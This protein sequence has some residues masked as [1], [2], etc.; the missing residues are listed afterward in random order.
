MPKLI[1]WPK[2]VSKKLSLKMI[3]WELFVITPAKP[4]RSLKQFH[5]MPSPSSNLII[6]IALPHLRLFLRTMSS[7]WKQ[8]IPFVKQYP[9]LRGEMHDLFD[10]LEKGKDAD[11]FKPLLKEVWVTWGAIEEA[12]KQ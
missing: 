2:L 9:A 6:A 8:M 12:M 11:E 4:S 5:N 3:R 10:E 1:I 7:A